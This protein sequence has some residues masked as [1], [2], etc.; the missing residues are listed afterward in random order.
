MTKDLVMFLCVCRK[1]QIAYTS[2]YLYIIIYCVV[3]QS[4]RGV[5]SL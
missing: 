4:L 2:L 5:H 3:V 1:L